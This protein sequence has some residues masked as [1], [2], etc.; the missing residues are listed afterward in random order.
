MH[1]Q[2]EFTICI[3]SQNR[4]KKMLYCCIPKSLKELFHEM[5][6]AFDFYVFKDRKQ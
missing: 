3:C 4:G 1:F 6:L 5:D 2:V